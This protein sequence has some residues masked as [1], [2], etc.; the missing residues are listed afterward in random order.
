MAYQH[1]PKTFD[2]PNKNPPA[3]PPTY[4]MYGPLNGEKTIYV[5]AD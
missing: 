2:G 3:T 1:M 4:L 5:F